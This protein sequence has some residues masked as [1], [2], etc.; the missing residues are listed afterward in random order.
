MAS[1]TVSGETRAAVREAATPAPKPERAP[2]A[3]SMKRPADISDTEWA[4]MKAAHNE[5]VPKRINEIMGDTGKPCEAE[6]A[7][8]LL[9][10][11]SGVE[12]ATYRRIKSLREGVAPKIAAE[13]KTAKSLV[14][15]K[16][17]LFRIATAV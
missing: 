12:H 1:A 2:R 10:I 14:D 11:V 4:I 9:E 17:R 15:V 7:A 6:E 16:M 13:A 3:P 5:D 8:V